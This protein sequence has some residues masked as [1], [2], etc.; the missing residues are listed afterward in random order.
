MLQPDRQLRVMCKGGEKKIKS[1]L[2]A[3]LENDRVTYEKFYAVFN[4]Q[5]KFGVAGE[6]GVHKEAT[7]D[8]LMF[9]SH[10]QGNTQTR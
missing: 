10:K 7:Q 8:L 9:Y 5:L 3:M 2:K 6:Y 1:E 4:R